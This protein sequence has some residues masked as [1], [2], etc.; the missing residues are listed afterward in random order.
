MEAAEDNLGDSSAQPSS[1]WALARL[2]SNIALILILIMNIF[3][4]GEVGAVKVES[5]TSNLRNTTPP[6]W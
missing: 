1:P 5:P 3:N 2:F 4:T 6:P